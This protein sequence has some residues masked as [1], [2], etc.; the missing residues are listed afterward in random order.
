M[1][2][3]HYTSLDCID[4]SH[5][6]IKTL[7]EEKTDIDRLRT[8]ELE[9]CIKL[10]EKLAEAEKQAEA[11][12][13]AVR[14]MEAQQVIVMEAEAKLEEERY[15]PIGSLFHTSCHLT[16]LTNRKSAL[17]DFIDQ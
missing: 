17:F 16:S 14:S 1:R 9:M 7:S 15:V 13:S 3:Q 6:R 4:Q 12:E 2:S 11:G 10:R 8:A 5:H